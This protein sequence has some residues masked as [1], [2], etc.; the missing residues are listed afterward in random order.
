[1]R[2]ICALLRASCACLAI[3]PTLAAFQKQDADNQDEQ[4]GPMSAATFAGLELRSIG[5]AL[6][7]GLGKLRASK[8]R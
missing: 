6:R 4:V 1:M 3:S 8:P 5:P 2:L 7:S